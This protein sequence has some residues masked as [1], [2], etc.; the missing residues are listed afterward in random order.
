LGIRWFCASQLSSDK[1]ILNTY[2]V[3]DQVYSIFEDLVEEWV[4][5]V[6]SLHQSLVGDRIDKMVE[7]VS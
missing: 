2:V 4:L 7:A 6:D 1:H 3:V 5:E